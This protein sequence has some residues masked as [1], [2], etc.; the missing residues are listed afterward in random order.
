MPGKIIAR[1]VIALLALAAIVGA[2]AWLAAR[3]YQPTIDNLNKLLA[4]CKAEKRQQDAAIAAQNNGVTALRLMAD[5][6]ESNAKAAQ[7]SARKSAQA[8][9]AAANTVLSE[10]TYGEACAAASAAFDN[11]LRRERGK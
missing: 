8:D 10:Q 1:G 3:H 9:Y 5:V 7:L 6:R 2:G 11:E 4:T